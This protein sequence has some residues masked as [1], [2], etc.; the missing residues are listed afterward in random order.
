MPVLLEAFRCCLTPKI[1]WIFCIVFLSNFTI[2]HTSFYETGYVFLLFLAKLETL[3]TVIKS[4]LSLIAS[5]FLDVFSSIYFLLPSYGIYAVHIF[6]KKQILFPC[7]F[8]KFMTTSIKFSI[9]YS[10]CYFFGI[11]LF[12]IFSGLSIFNLY[13]SHQEIIDK[14]LSLYQ[15]FKNGSLDFWIK[16]IKNLPSLFTQINQNFSQF[17]LTSYINIHF[18]KLIFISIL[19]YFIYGIGL[20]Y[21]FTKNLKISAF[22][23]LKKHFVF[24][25]ENINL[26][27]HLHFLLFLIV[28]FYIFIRFFIY[29]QILINIVLSYFLS[30]GLYLIAITF[31]KIENN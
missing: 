3:D 26:I 6:L 24:F 21:E 10:I 1:I 14:T 30:I 15:Q 28:C 18:Y 4:C 5:N 13:L 17:S 16:N 25:K 12:F 29:N 8:I 20:I 27:L 23:H 31:K 2:K 7:P 22:F 9:L 11:I 19:I